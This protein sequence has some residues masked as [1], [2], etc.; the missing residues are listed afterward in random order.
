[1]GRA[2]ADRFLAQGWTAVGVDRDADA[3]SDAAPPRGSSY[4]PVL[5]DITDRAAL[6]AALGSPPAGLRAIVNA[7]GIYP[8][9]TLA[10]YDEATYRR[11]FDVSSSAPSTSSPRPSPPCGPPAAAP[12]STSPP[13]TP[14]QSRQANSSTAPPRPGSSH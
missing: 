6:A 5:V 7:A 4:H 11:I 14:S 10:D 2:V 12:S 3:L 8:T 13:S 9:T 1:V